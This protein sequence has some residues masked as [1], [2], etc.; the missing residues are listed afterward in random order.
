MLYC[1]TCNNTRLFG[2]S[3]VPSVAPTANGSLS[4][5][6]GNFDPSGHIETITSL[7]ADKKT[8]AAARKNPQEYFDLCLA[9]GGQDVVWQDEDE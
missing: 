2:S 5:M 6:T 1:K 8:L 7:G 9:C 4:A 3:K